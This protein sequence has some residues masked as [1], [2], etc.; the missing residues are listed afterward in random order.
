MPKDMVCPA[1]GVEM[2]FGS[3][4]GNFEYQS[5][6]L[7]RLSLVKDMSEVMWFGYLIKQI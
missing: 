6:R 4:D 5:P 1:L 7:T 3:S 2:R